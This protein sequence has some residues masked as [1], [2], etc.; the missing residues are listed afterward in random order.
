M[1]GDHWG[2]GS[3]HDHEESPLAFVRALSASSDPYLKQAAVAYSGITDFLGLQ[4]ATGPA[5]PTSYFAAILSSLAQK[6][7]HTPDS[8]GGLSYLLARIV[9]LVP[10]AVLNLKSEEFA[11]LSLALLRQHADITFLTKQVL[12]A[13]AHVLR[14][15]PASTLVAKTRLR[16]LQGLLVFVID[17]RPK[18]RRLSQRLTAAVFRQLSEHGPGP[19]RSL[20]ALAETDSDA[21]R[22]EHALA[23]ALAALGQPAVS[24][25]GV[26]KPVL[27]T[28]VRFA[29]AE[30]AACSRK[31][32]QP[33][34]YLC[35]ALQLLVPYLPLPVCAQLLAELLRLAAEGN[36]FLTLQTFR[37]MARTLSHGLRTQRALAA[38]AAAAA[39][40][41]SVAPGPVAAALGLTRADALTRLTRAGDFVTQLLSSAADIVPPA[42]DAAGCGAYLAFVKAAFASLSQLDAPRAVALAP[43]YVASLSELMGAVAAD[44][45]L[46]EAAAAAARV[47][48]K[49][50]AHPAAARSGEHTSELQ[51][52]SDLVC[53]PRRRRRARRC[54]ARARLGAP[55]AGAATGPR[56][57]EQGGARRRGRRDAGCARDA[58][59]EAHRAG[60]VAARARDAAR[61]APRALGHRDA[62]RR[63]RRARGH[64]GHRRHRRRSRRGHRRARARERRGAADARRGALLRVAASDG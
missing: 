5:A 23:T 52:H 63:R 12:V 10:P 21:A 40:A 45:T 18:V 57:A 64:R 39:A 22:E 32:C 29:Q 4:Q 55:G 27:E 37:V 9:P 44:K 56:Q 20:A 26:P 58:L 61:V 35:G 54:A 14:V 53:R 8:L 30:L 43:Q 24:R 34:L 13:I 33:A 2:I 47:V 3:G 11:E 36:V 59:R 6:G 62:H 17:P 41:G 16:M 42:T 31:D 46:A 60:A 28:L 49:A 50:G 51:S 38:A 7:R 48:V 1:E 19:V 15:L 25:A